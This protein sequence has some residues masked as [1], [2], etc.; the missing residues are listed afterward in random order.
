MLIFKQRARKLESFDFDIDAIRFYIKDFIAA[1]AVTMI[2]SRANQG[3]TWLLFAICKY[4][5]DNETDVGEVLYFDLDNGK[6]TLKQRNIEGYLEIYDKWEYYISANIDMS[7]DELM[8]SLREDCHSNNFK[9]KILIFD[10][11]RDFLSDLSND[12]RVKYF[13]NTMKKIRDN[14]GTVILI[15]HTT[16]N[17]KVIDGSGEFEKSVDNLYYLE[18][19][20]RTG[21]TLHY[22]LQ[23][24]KERDPI[25]D[26]GFSVDTDTL[27]LKELDVTVAAMNA[28]EEEFIEKIKTVLVKHPTGIKQGKLLESV[29]SSSTNKTDKRTLDKFEN[30]FYKK[31]AEGNSF[32]YSRL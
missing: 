3:K 22:S 16:K 25:I 18:Q 30:V 9:N 1:E 20:N 11:T 2:Y 29:G 26:C 8:D 4:I 15:H 24:Q 28:D 5:L 10:S 17:G 31:E 19:K 23:V 13:M 32:L 27:T 21:N 6:R 12:R 14:G 7:S